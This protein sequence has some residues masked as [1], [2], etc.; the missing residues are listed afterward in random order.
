MMLHKRWVKISLVVLVIGYLSFA[1]KMFAYKSDETICPRIRVTI[2]DA[3]NLNFVSKEDVQN[4]L[5]DKSVYPI[6]VRLDHINTDRLENYLKGKS[7]IKTAECFKTPNGELNVRVTQ[8][9]PILRV[10]GIYGD[11]YVDSERKM[12]PT[13]TIFT[14][15]VPIA[16]GY[17][18][19]E[20]SLGE[21]GEFALFLR[22]HSFWNAQIEQID[23]A[24]NGEVTLVPRVGDQLILMGTLENYQDK[25]D[26][27]YAL[28]V[29]G[30][31]KIGWNK[32]KQITLKYEG[33]V[34]CTKR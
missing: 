27:L 33:Q 20:M 30:F 25:L 22:D 16:T 26:R 13:S 2:A 15:Y 1:V 28:Y 32:Y 4:L 18:T 7:R 29:N 3:Q 9:E 17:V 31:N 5:Q 12:M 24:K 34:V 14:A 10:K 11:Y 21:L 8:R 23:V 19:K 6:G